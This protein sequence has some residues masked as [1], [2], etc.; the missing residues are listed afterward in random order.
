MNS[1]PGA[2]AAGTPLNISAVFERMCETSK[3]FS[4]STAQ[5]RKFDNDVAALRQLINRTPRWRPAQVDDEA[6]MIDTLEQR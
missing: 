2:S 6:V 4:M 5:R 3:V 1:P